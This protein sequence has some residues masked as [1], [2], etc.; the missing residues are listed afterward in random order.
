V[1]GSYTWGG[2]NATDNTVF[3]YLA[4]RKSRKSRTFIIDE[5]GCPNLKPVG[6]SRSLGLGLDELNSAI[7]PSGMRA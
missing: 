1:R 5:V 6:G 3:V 2:D 7:S 4:L